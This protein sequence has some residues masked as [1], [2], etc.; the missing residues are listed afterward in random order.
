MTVENILQD[1]NDRDFIFNFQDGYGIGDDEYSC[2]YDGCRQLYWHCAQSRP[3]SHPPW[4][5][6]DVL[7][8][9]LDLD[10]SEVIFYLNG[11]PL[12]A[13]SGLFNSAKSVWGMFFFLLL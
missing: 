12:P 1:I 7:G 5:E 13:E 2:A 8:L 3:H 6:G 9:L 10:Q 4:K 11:D